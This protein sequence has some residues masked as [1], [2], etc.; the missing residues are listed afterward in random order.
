MRKADSYSIID[1]QLLHGRY[2]H[3]LSHESLVLYLFL[4]VVGD[5]DGKS[6][7]GDRTIM[8]IL[9]FKVSD[10]DNAREELIKES[11]INYRSP[12]WLVNPIRRVSFSNVVK[13]LNNGKGK[14][15][16]RAKGKGKV[17]EGCSEIK[18]S[19]DKPASRD[20]AKKYIQDISRSIW[21]DKR[22]TSASI[23]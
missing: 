6:F 18:L 5:S 22:K 20:F 2:L 1:H 21:G 10:L 17:S 3:S 14:G 4:V 16:G 11:L 12:Y 7:Y 13:N 19:A 15:N 23:R 8:G 9:R